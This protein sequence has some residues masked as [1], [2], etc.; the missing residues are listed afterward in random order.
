MNRTSRRSPSR[1]PRLARSS[2]SLDAHTKEAIA[3]FVRVLAACGCSPEEIGREVV[4][5]C[6]KAPKSWAK[7]ALLAVP[8]IEAAAHVLT[9]WFSEPEFVDPS[10]NPRPLPLKGAGVSLERLIKRVAPNVQPEAVLGHLLQQNILRRVRNGYLPR[11]RFVCFE[12][13]EAAYKFRSLRVL[14]SMLRTVE[15]NSSPERSGRGWFEVSALNPRFPVREREAFDQRL[16]R[17]AMRLLVQLDADMHRRERARGPGEP[18]LPLGVGIYRWEEE[19]SP[20]APQRRR[21]RK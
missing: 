17:A 5:A 12:G 16:R 3:R 19:P 10:G 11:E 14:L 15:Y 6:Q 8:D 20:A 4:A 7:I 18:T 2:T 1:E 21:R 9:L 13:S